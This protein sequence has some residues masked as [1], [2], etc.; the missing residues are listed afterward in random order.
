[1]FDVRNGLKKGQ[2]R[3]GNSWD[4]SAHPRDKGGQFTSGGGES[5]GGSKKP[6]RAAGIGAG[7]KRGVDPN[8]E[9]TGRMRKHM[10]EKVGET[11]SGKKVS[12]QATPKELKSYSAQDHTDAE[13]VH[14]KLARHMRS[15]DREK[16]SDKDL[17]LAKHHDA[18][19]A[20]HREYRLKMKRPKD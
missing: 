6:G 1:M 3:Y 16:P 17:E 12:W 4:E 5:G 20:T 10:A 19:A 13:K 14:Q 9:D 8:P 11:R 2:Q 15:K 7:E 18:M